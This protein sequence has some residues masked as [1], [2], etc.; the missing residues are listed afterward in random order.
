MSGTPIKAPTRLE[1]LAG[2]GTESV[3]RVE[4]KA[5]GGEHVIEVFLRESDTT[6]WQACYF[7][8]DNGYINGLVNSEYCNPAEI[9][10]VMPTRV[11]KTE[12]IYT[13]IK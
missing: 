7:V 8:S 4:E 2:I 11:K 10:Q 5:S 9:T 1:L 6:Y 12:Y 3:R 13:P